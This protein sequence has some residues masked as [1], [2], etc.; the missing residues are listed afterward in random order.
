MQAGAALLPHESMTEE[1][2]GDC[3]RG[4]DEDKLDS[5]PVP[6]TPH[7]GKVGL[8]ALQELVWRLQVIGDL[9]PPLLQV[10]VSE[11]EQAP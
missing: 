9:Q 3:S 4:A 2:G 6:P 10:V 11:L 1:V 5:R 7:L 8:V